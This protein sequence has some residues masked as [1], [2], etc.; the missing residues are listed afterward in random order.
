M[1]KLL[2]KYVDRHVLALS[3]KMYIRSHLDYGDVIYHNHRIDLSR[4]SA[5]VKGV[6]HISTNLKVNM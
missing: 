6:E 3:Y 2:S 5:V 4:R 1:L